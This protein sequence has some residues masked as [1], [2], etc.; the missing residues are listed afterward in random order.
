MIIMQMTNWV[1]E[2]T[3]GGKKW[4]DTEVIRVHDTYLIVDR[5][6]LNHTMFYVFAGTC[7]QSPHTCGKS[8]K[9]LSL[10]RGTHLHTS[11]LGDFFR[12]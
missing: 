7:V 6:V 4:P 2:D 12:V 10:E 8:G 11:P 3:Q 5:L 1:F 9:S